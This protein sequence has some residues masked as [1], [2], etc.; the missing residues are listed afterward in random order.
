MATRRGTEAK[1]PIGASGLSAR[2]IHRGGMFMT[3][4]SQRGVIRFLALSSLLIVPATTG[5][6]QR[7]PIVE[8]LAKTYGLDSFGQIEAIRYT[9]NAQAPGLDLSRSWT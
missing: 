1:C 4:L 7:A 6:Q 2:S 8:K 9:F 5:A 3:I